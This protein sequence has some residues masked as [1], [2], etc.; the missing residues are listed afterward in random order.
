MSTDDSGLAT[1][2][3]G[4]GPTPLPSTLR[5][6]RLTAY[7]YTALASDDPL[8]PFLRLDFAAALGR[9]QRIKAEL[10]PLLAAWRTADVDVLL[11]KGFQLSEFVYQQP[12]AR[13]HGDVDILIRPAHVRRAEQI[14]VAMGWHSSP[15]VRLPLRHNHCAFVLSSIEGVARVDV[16]QEIIHAFLPWHST[17]RRITASVW[18]NST[19]RQ[20][21]GVE[22]REPSPVDMLLVALVLQRA[23]GSEAWQIKPHDIIDFRHITSRLGVTRDDLWARAR[24]LRCER[25]LGMFL[26]R[27]DPDAARLDLSPIPA[28]QLRRF[29]ARA[30]RERGLLGNIEV[31]L[32]RVV[33]APFALPLAL[34]FVPTVL[35][36]RRALRRHADLWSLLET[37]TPKPAAVHRD[38]LMTRDQLVSGVHWAQRLVGSGPFGMCLVRALA[39]F[40]EL[41]R[42]GTTVDFVSGVRRN[43]ATIGGHAWLEYDGG[44]PWEFDQPETRVLFSENFRFPGTVKA[45]ERRGRAPIEPTRAAKEAAESATRSH[46]G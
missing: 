11:F 17:Q 43:G 4:H 6:A 46:R 23:W 31:N 35:R 44:I 7:A 39:G 36:V 2:L 40:I 27:C 19:T 22:V 1:W 34:R 38:D 12:G 25:T 13:Y 15:L 29:Q 18:D 10:Q 41:K 42:R 32:A 8:R 16:H 21:N 24:E 14:A 45:R 3:L 5:T 30:F 26:D 28:R 37:L 20:W 9:H 33:G